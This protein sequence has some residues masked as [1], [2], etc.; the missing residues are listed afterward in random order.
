[1]IELSRKKMSQKFN[2]QLT[3]PSGDENEAQSYTVRDIVPNGTS[4]CAT[5]S[6]T[7][8]DVQKVRSATLS[9]TKN[10]HSLGSLNA[11]ATTRP[12]QCLTQAPLIGEPGPH[13]QTLVAREGQERE[14]LAFS[15]SLVGSECLFLIKP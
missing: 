3:E 1:M 2:G 15:I 12:Q 13:A 8:V 6:S 11:Q 7:T 10:G 5:A 4:M 14:N 9:T